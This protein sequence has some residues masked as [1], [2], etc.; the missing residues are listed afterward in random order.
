MNRDLIVSIFKD[1]TISDL[2]EIRNTLLHCVHA[3]GGLRN[4]ST[5]ERKIKRTSY[6]ILFLKNVLM[7]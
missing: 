4:E 1:S 6:F 3:C 5:M 2:E 7:H